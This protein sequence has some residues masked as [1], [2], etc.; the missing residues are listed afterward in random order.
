MNR[1]PTDPPA[2]EAWDPQADVPAERASRDPQ[3]GRLV[4]DSARQRQNEGDVESGSG[5][6]RPD[7]DE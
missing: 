6:G 4:P 3:K 7:G 5:P 2:Q 1:Q